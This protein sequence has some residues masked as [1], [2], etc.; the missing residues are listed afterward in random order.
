MSKKY[1]PFKL[2]QELTAA[3]VGVVSVD[4]NG[5]IVLSEPAPQQTA[6]AEQVKAAHLPL[7]DVRQL[8]LAAIP[9]ALVVSMVL[10][11]WEMVVE[12]KEARDVPFLSENG[13]ALS[14]ARMAA[15]R[16]H[17]SQLEEYC[18]QTQSAAEDEVQP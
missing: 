3:G 7:A 1:L 17:A 5:D 12:R 14:A 4:E 16:E 15:A 2:H 10:T 9:H 18:R 11:L 13:A 8:E 6:L